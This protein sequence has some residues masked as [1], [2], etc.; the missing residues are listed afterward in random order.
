MTEFDV[1]IVGG[2]IYPCADNTLSSIPNGVVAIKDGRVAYVGKGE[3]FSGSA[4]R[5]LN[6]SGRFVLPG[7]CD[8]HTHLVYGGNRID[9]FARKMAGESYQSIA[10]AGG[11]IM[12]TVRATRNATD[13]SLFES[14]KAR[15]LQMRAHGVTTVE[16]KSGYGLSIDHELRLLRVARRLET[17]GV[18]RTHV[19]LLGAHTVPEE[20]R[21]DRA[22][23]LKDVV[24]AMIPRAASEKLCDGVDVYIDEGAF[25]LDEGRQV[26]EAAAKA[27][28]TRRA[29]IGQFSDLGGAKML[30]EL[31]AL[32][33][34][35]LEHVSDEGLRALHD[36]NVVATLLPGAWRTLRQTA[37]NAGR[38][39]G[40]G[41]TMAIGTDCNPGTSP[42]T[43]LTLCAA[44]AVRDAGLTLDE[45]LL[46]I[47]A[48]AGRALGSSTLGRL[49]VG[50]PADIAIYA[51]DDARML[52]YALGG[53]RAEHVLLSGEL[54][55]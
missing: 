16:V 15:A 22:G 3:S 49:T 23:Y 34:D 46:G 14:A 48:N 9:E 5:T 2:R 12:S 25:T 28:L 27:G 36:G 39:R 52:G 26:L 55:Q 10:Q 20:R 42:C 44:L 11:G 8:P 40:R 13:E 6:A 30:A 24:E 54:V 35:H 29:H 31:G 33:A 17:E 1:A 37:P 38:M 4:K 19:T 47:T 43:D 45:A 53:V 50:N 32:S 18:V 21:N 41:V 7:L 51:G